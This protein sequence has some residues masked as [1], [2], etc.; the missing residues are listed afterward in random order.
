MERN[1]GKELL[2]NLECIVFDLDRTLIDI[3]KSYEQAIKNSIGKYL[4]LK[5][6]DYAKEKE[7]ISSEAIYKLFWKPELADVWYITYAGIEYC[8]AESI[9]AG[10]NPNIKYDFDEFVPFLLSCQGKKYDEVILNALK[11]KFPSFESESA[12]KFDSLWDK[13]LAKDIFQAE[14]LGS[15]WYRI[16]YGKECPVKAKGFYVNDSAIPNDEKALQALSFLSKRFKLGI[17]TARPKSEAIKILGN[18]G[19]FRFFSKDSVFCLEDGSKA[20]RILKALKALDFENGK[21]AYAGDAIGD[22]L[23]VNEL[24]KQG[25]DIISIGVNVAASDELMKEQEKKLK[26]AG[27]DIFLKDF[28]TIKG[29]V[30]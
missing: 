18:L 25:I 13:G 7:I 14:F 15:D 23:A 6:I 17:A 22:V 1:E 11:E 8:L 27:V 21:S 19:Y 9:S 12:E 20:E 24:K 26:E 4:E 5:G 2:N 16:E 3:T 10:G 30:E 29:L 28:S